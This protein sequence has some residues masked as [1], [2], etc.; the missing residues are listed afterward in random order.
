[1]TTNKSDNE[2]RS[3]LQQVSQGVSTLSGVCSLALVIFYGGGLVKT[4]EGHE[5]RIEHLE[6]IG[7]RTVT[8]HIKVD[9]TREAQ[10]DKRVST[11]ETEIRALPRIE[12]NVAAIK[13]RLE[14]LVRNQKDTK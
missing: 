7:S 13:E 14:E 3:V 1:M 4:V 2:K 12:A 10:T 11:I 5:V 8:E 6:S 9:D